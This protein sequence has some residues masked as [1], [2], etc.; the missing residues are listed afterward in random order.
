MFRKIKCRFSPNCIDDEECFFEHENISSKHAEEVKVEKRRYCPEG[1][2]C[3]NQSCDNNETNHMGVK[4]VMSRFQAKCN[5]PEFM[6]K[7]VVERAAFLGDCSQN[8]M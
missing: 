8:F 5:R 7:H 1:E 4:N 3:Q 2:Q 6:F